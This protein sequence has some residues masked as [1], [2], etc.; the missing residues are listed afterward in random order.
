M[1]LSEL[2]LIF[3]DYWDEDPEV[4]AFGRLIE[5]VEYIPTHGGEPCLPEQS[6]GGRVNLL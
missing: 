5:D 2:L 4:F 3:E 6:D 1:R